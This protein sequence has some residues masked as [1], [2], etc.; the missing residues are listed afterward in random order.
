MIST[1]ALMLVSATV[2]AEL[3]REV[4][5]GGRPRPEFLE[6][7]ARGVELLDWSRLPGSPG[8]RSARAALLQV[9]AA[10]PRLRRMDAVFSDSEQVGIPLALAMLATGARTR[11]LMLG[12]HL[13]N[14]RKP[15]LLRRLRPQ[16]RVDRILVHSPRQLE[17]AA[18]ELGIP[19][20]RLTFDPYFVDTDFWSPRPGIREEPLIVSAGL[21]HRDYAT[22]AAAWEGRPEPVFVAAGSVHSPGA[23]ARLP[24]RWPDGFRVEGVAPAR[25]RELYARASVVVVPVVETDFQAGITVVLEAMA[26]GKAVVATAAAGWAGAI[27]HGADGLLV[28][29]GDVVAL[30]GAM[31]LLFDDPRLRARLGRVARQT[32]VTRFGL[33]AYA[34]RLQGHLEDLGGTLRAAA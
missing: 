20:A 24:V 26:M 33:P 23:A 7:E 34:D 2:S 27:T 29:P 5:Q 13:S 16:R 30:R 31:A 1:R 17:L 6:L 3:R 18:G 19:V 11:H 9:A 21:E 15:A 28:P 4:A 8:R 22:L 32:A 14:G 10:L 25:L 12:H